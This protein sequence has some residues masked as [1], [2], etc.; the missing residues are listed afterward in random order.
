MLKGHFRPQ[1][2]SDFRGIFPDAFGTFKISAA[3]AP[4]PSPNIK[5]LLVSS[6]GI[7]E[8]HLLPFFCI[9]QQIG[10]STF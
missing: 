8:I 10:P 2:A 5:P 4:P 6:M 7:S 3:L 1:K 9:V